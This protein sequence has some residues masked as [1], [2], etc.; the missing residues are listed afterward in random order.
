VY[1]FF[2][3]TTLIK[4]AQQAQA[5]FMICLLATGLVASLFGGTLSDKY[6]RRI[7]ITISTSFLGLGCFGMA[8]LTFN[9]TLLLMC[10][11]LMGIGVGAF[12]AADLG[13]ANDIIDPAQSAKELSM[14]QVAQTLPMIISAPLGGLIVQISEIAN[15]N[16]IINI[17]HIGYN[18]MLIF[19]A[20]LCAATA[21]LIWCIR[22]SPKTKQSIVTKIPSDEEESEFS[23]V[24]SLVE[25][26]PYSYQSQIDVDI[27]TMNV[28]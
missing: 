8:F 4:N 16:R 20:S 5:V 17:D 13:L 14:F 15:K 1:N 25:H 21:S 2:S 27:N 12:F 10:A 28:K 23:S 26:K 7:I 24:E 11:I 6:G 19:G 9:Y 18:I 22:V 3:S